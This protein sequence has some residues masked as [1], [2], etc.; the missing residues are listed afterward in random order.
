VNEQPTI[1]RSSAQ[2]SARERGAPAREPAVSK[3]GRKAIMA[4]YFKKQKEMKKLSQQN[5]DK[6]LNSSWADTSNM[7]LNP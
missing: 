3:E 2:N 7:K 5:E 1:E 6:Y 4:Q